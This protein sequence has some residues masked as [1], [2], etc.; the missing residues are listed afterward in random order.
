MV[1][2]HDAQYLADLV[3]ELRR[4]PHE[5]EW[6]EFKANR[7]DHQD[8]GEYISALANGA[9]LNGK[10]AAHILWGI[11]DG[12]HALIG[13]QFKPEGAKTGNVPLEN[14]LR[15]GLTPPLDFH[16]Y[17]VPVD[18]KRVV[19]LEIAPATQ[20]PAA[21]TVRLQGTTLHPRRQRQETPP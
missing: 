19:I 15:R 5:T 12:A 20:Q 10:N 16:F 17:E 1:P 7:A 8:I 18:D 14:W 2:H 13:T 11:A 6:V 9:A 4:L 3:S 21:F